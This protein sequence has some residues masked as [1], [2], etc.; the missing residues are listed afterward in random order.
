MAVRPPE[1]DLS[2]LK[3][4]EHARSRR[5]SRWLRW[6]AAAVGVCFLVFALGFVL[7]GKAPSVQLAHRS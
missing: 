4:D 1:P 3:I 7:I 5:G 2:A 6:V